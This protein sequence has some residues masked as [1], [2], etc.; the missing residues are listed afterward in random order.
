MP[1]CDFKHR[2]LH[3]LE[4]RRDLKL[5]P[6]GGAYEKHFCCVYTKVSQL[7]SFY[8]SRRSASPVSSTFATVVSL[9]ATSWP[10]IGGSS[11]SNSIDWQSTGVDCLQCF[12]HLNHSSIA[13]KR[14]EE[15][16]VSSCSSVI[17]A[18]DH[19]F[20]SL[21]QCSLAECYKSAVH[22]AL[23]N[24]LGGQLS[25]PVPSRFLLVSP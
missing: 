15:E 2:A 18:E 14:M 25:I 20:H 9:R 12:Y 3:P 8:G 5:N 7:F 17:K 4:P 21:S 13:S 24:C 11:G 16:C 1:G 23:I 10:L 22:T 6:P 19:V